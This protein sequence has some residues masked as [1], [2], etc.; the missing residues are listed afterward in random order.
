MR[1]TLCVPGTLRN[2]WMEEKILNDKRVCL[3]HILVRDLGIDKL[4]IRG[5]GLK[6]TEILSFYKMKYIPCDKQNCPIFC[7]SKLLVEKLYTTS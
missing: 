4:D 1:L 5:G 7:R 2:K 3:Q 6:F